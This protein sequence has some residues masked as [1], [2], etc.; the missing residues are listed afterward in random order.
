MLIV[1]FVSRLLC[2]KMRV[3][4]RGGVGVGARGVDLFQTALKNLAS[5]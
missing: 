3:C 5:K 1:L 4:V 2:R